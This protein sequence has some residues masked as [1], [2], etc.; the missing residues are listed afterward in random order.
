MQVVNSSL[1]VVGKADR[2]S[3]FYVKESDAGIIIEY[4]PSENVPCRTINR[5]NRWG[6]LKVKTRRATCYVILDTVEHRPMDVHYWEDNYC[7]L[8]VNE[9]GR[10]FN[11]RKYLKWEVESNTFKFRGLIGCCQCQLEPSPADGE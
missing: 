4:R 3:S 8:K 7:N 11:V 5:K 1:T 6:K 9:S 2:P 10:K